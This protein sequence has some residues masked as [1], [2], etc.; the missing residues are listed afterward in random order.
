M[1]K[2]EIIDAGLIKYPEGINLQSEVWQKR[3]QEQ[4]PDTFILCEHYPVITIGRKGGKE[5]L[6]VPE[7]SLNERGVE[8]YQVERG[9]DT[10]YHCPG[11]LVGYPIFDL[12][13]HGMDLHKF[14]RNIEEVIINALTDTGIESCRRK[15]YTGVWVCNNGEFEKIAFIGISA[16]RWI[17]FHGFS[18]NVDCDLTPFSWIVPCGLK[19]VR[20]TSVKEV[21]ECQS[22]KTVAAGFSLREFQIREI[23]KKIIENF[24]KVFNLKID[25]KEIAPVA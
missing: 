8:V 12:Q 6:L 19:G 22:V 18:L 11:Q 21:S 2:L 1:N 9:G 10:T 7:K 17:T 24:T 13:C 25:E 4:I 20:V 15:G 5:D 3:L 23:K 16:S 14:L